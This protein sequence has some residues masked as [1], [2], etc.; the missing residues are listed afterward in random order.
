VNTHARGLYER[1]GFQQTGRM[2]GGIQVGEAY[3]DDVL[4]TLELA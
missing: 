2:P 3:V 1:L 4:M